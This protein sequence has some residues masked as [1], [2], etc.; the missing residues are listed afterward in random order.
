LKSSETFSWRGVAFANTEGGRRW[1]AVPTPTCH[2]D[3]S[4]E[5][6]PDRPGFLFVAIIRSNPG[7]KTGRGKTP[8]A[9][10]DDAFNAWFI[11]FHSLPAEPKLEPAETPA[12]SKCATCWRAAFHPHD[13][14]DT[15]RKGDGLGGAS[16]A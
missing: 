5:H 4:V 2:L 8:G 13:R 15:C 12:Y 9:A 11:F 3:A 6:Y 10:L 14:C 16:K 7:M 1:D